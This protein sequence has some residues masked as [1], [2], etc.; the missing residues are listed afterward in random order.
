M[1]GRNGLDEISVEETI[2]YWLPTLSP[3]TQ[4]SYISGIIKKF[5]DYIGDRIGH[6]FVTRSGKPDMINQQAIIFA[7]V[8]KTAEIPFKVSPQVLRAS[9]VAYFKQQRIWEQ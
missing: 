6:V 4:L 9:V 1:K 5:R 2:S 3:K 7:K 8:G